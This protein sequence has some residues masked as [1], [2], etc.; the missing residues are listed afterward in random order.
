MRAL[1][2]V[3]VLIALLDDSHVHHESARRWLG[4]NIQYGWASSPLTQLGCVRIMSSA[5]Y[6]N[7][8]PAAQ[9]AARLANAVAGPHHEFWSAEINAL[10]TGVLDWAGLL[11]PRHITDLYLLAL[12]V[13]RGGRLVTFDRHIPQ[14]L[15]RNAEP[16][17][18]AMI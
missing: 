14:Q 15:V 7:S 9:V 8:K 17:N 16:S 2:D 10:S 5:S 13:Q 12:A 6:P 18:L 11:S 1:L 3:N 4:A